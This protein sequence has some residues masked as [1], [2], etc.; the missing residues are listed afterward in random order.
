MLAMLVRDGECTAGELGKP[1][2]FAQ[3]TISKHIKVLENAGLIHRQIDGRVHRFRLVSR[4]L[5]EAEQ[6]IARHRQF[7]AGTLERLEGFVLDDVGSEGE[8]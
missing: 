3:P 2:S 7:W 4:P 6:W 1:F 8:A 5:E